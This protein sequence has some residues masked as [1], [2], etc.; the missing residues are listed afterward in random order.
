MREVFADQEDILRDSKFVEARMIHGYHYHSESDP[1]RKTVESDNIRT[2]FELAKRMGNRA[3]VH[4]RSQHMPEA[5]SSALE[6]VSG[7]QFQGLLKD[8]VA[9]EGMPLMLLSN[10][11]PQFGIFNGAICQ[12]KGLLYLPDDVNV[13]LK[14]QDLKKLK[15]TDLVVQEPFDLRGGNNFSR[16]H[17]LPK[18]TVLVSINNQPVSCEDDLKKAIDSGVST[19]CLFRLPRAPPALPDFLVA[20]SK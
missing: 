9:Y 6:L 20:E 14:S 15:I 13:K 11:A 7:K 3:V 10:F 5:N 4:L 17:Q 12:F 19:E 1:A 2:M 16:L 8:F 18:G